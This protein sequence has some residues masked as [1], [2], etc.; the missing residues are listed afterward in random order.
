MLPYLPDGPPPAQSR[1]RRRVLPAAAAGV[2]GAGVAVVAELPGAGRAG[3]RPPRRAVG[4]GVG[5]GAGLA[6]P[7]AA[8]ADRAGAGGRGGVAV[9]R[10]VAAGQRPRRV[11]AEE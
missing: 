4:G 2:P 5:P 11:V 6:D 8:A 9:P 3:V 10:G 1:P 7:R